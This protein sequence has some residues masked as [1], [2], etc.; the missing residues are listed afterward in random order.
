MNWNAQGY[1]TVDKER[2]WKEF[3]KGENTQR[4]IYDEFRPNVTEKSR[5]PQIKIS[6]RGKKFLE[7]PVVHPK[8]LYGNVPQP[9]TAS[10]SSTTAGATTSPLSV[11]GSNG[12]TDTAATNATVTSP[13]LPQL[14][15][16]QLGA[17]VT[18][19]R[20]LPNF[21]LSPTA[22]KDNGYSP[23]NLGNTQNTMKATDPL[24]T[25]RL[26]SASSHEVGGCFRT[27]KGEETTRITSPLRQAIRTEGE[28]SLFDFSKKK[29]RASIYGGRQM[30]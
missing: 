22:S 13:R 5:E 16:R 19:P 25:M 2:I 11:V 18:S 29:K 14:S 27:E 4:H 1:S 9:P 8:G 24:S 23:R 6:P 28:H 10:P 30:Q 7:K 15:P 21:P 12:H 26:V 17:G 20:R 3:V